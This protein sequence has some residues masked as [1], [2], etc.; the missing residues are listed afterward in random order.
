VAEGPAGT[1]APGRFDTAIA[2]IDLANAEDPN[3][4]VYQGM[5]RP[6]ELL[7]SEMMTEWVL[8]LDPHADECQLLAAR[9]HHFRRWTSPRGDFPDGRAGYLRWRTRA[10]SRQAE[11]VGALL[12]EHGYGPD[13]IERVGEIIR[14]EH[15]TTDPAVQTHEDALCLVFLDTQLTELADK[16]GDDE[17]VEVLVKTIPKLSARGVEAVSQLSLSPRGAELVHRAVSARGNDPLA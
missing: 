15:R 17:V 4:L 1:P 6:K 5:A 3:E 10:K 7:H 9:A 14:K 11:E 8:R 12:A 16:L 2:A 13:E